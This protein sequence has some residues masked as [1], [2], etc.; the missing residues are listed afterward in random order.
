MG[1]IL[2]EHNQLQRND[3]GIWVLDDAAAFHYSDGEET[4]SYLGTVFEK[5]EDLG[6]YAVDLEDRII[7]WPSEYHLSFK[8]Y[9][10][11]RFLYLQ[12]CKRVLEL[13]CG[14]GAISRY[15]GEQGIEV[16]AVEGSAV[17][18]SLAQS[19]CRDLE[20][21]NI[22][23]ANYNDLKLPALA[24]DAVVFIGVLE[25]A[26]RFVEGA[27]SHEA[28]VR[29]ILNAVKLSL[30]ESGVAI[31]AIE[32]RLG[33]KYLY[34]AGEDH[35]AKPYMG[36]YGYPGKSDIKTYSLG[37]WKQLIKDSDFPCHEFAYCFPD[38]KIPSTIV[39]DNFLQ[40]PDNR[41]HLLDTTNSRDYVNLVTEFANE[42]KM[43]KGFVEA[44]Q[45]A[46]FANSFLMVLG[47]N[48][49]S[50]AHRMSHDFLHS[51]DY[52]RRPEF[53][54]ITLKSRQQNRLQK[55]P[56]F[57]E[58]GN[59]L[60]S[61]NLE[62]TDY[63]S[64][65][66]LSNIWAR[67][68]E[69]ENNSD[70]FIEHLRAYLEFVGKTLAES[71]QNGQW[72]DLLPFNIVVGNEGQFIAID[73]EWHYH[74]E[75]DQYYLLFRALFYFVGRYKH[76]FVPVFGEQAGVGDILKASFQQL[77]LENKLENWSAYIQL[78][79]QLQKIIRSPQALS[80][81]RLELRTKHRKIQISPGHLL[82]QTHRTDRPK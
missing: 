4:E 36:L 74:K 40:D 12:D 51:S 14:C 39:A 26:G 32:N 47:Q 48:S 28:A 41:I 31:I 56:L 66:L 65:E 44:G 24:Y 78:E 73:Q 52:S 15:L 46:E 76:C 79:D 69:I 64:G 23:N 55:Y 27:D 82:A 77:G 8:R 60:L 5:T 45:L 61:Q 57:P 75:F 72:I 10:L 63:C 11:L 43:L 21:V 20:N 53:R 16:D 35:Y 9:N 49:D 33:L 17:R 1:S 34:G 37:E 19:R 81:T 80:S 71:G 25:Y 68:L 3:Q 58:S 7:D 30:L 59:K 6:C 18:A 67:D 62:V 22:I 42:G 29:Q 50:V 2:A 38:Y 13:G 54:T 70:A